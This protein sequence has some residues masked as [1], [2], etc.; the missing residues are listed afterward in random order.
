M[1]RSLAPVFFVAVLVAGCAPERPARTAELTS[2][3]A[4]RGFSEADAQTA[5]AAASHGIKSCRTPDGP[6]ELDVQ[7][8]FEPS[9]KVSHV[10]IAPFD[11]EV[12]PCAKERLAKI[13]LQPFDGVARTI[14]T[15]VHL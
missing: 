7:L 12:A 13:E 14:R 1:M 4:P 5:I 8:R 11:P 3:D 15:R 6:K 10:D 2:G 9:G